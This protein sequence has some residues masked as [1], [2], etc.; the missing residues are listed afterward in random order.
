MFGEFTG[1]FIAMLLAYVV[2]FVLGYGL[3]AVM[4]AGKR[5]DERIQELL[6]RSERGER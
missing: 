3:C 5:H 1:H 4:A 2:G 6:D